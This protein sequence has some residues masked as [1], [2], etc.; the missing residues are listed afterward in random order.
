METLTVVVIC[1]FCLFFVFTPLCST[2]VTRRRHLVNPADLGPKDLNRARRKLSTVTACSTAAASVRPDSMVRT[3]DLE[4]GLFNLEMDECPI[5]IGPLVPEPL[6]RDEQSARVALAEVT[7][8]A[9]SSAE[10]SPAG[11]HEDASGVSSKLLSVL[12]FRKKVSPGS[13]SGDDVLTLTACGHSFHAK[14]LSSWFLIDRYDCP[15]CRI[16]Y[17][18][19]RPPSL[20]PRNLNLTLPS[21]HLAERSRTMGLG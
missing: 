2:I 8:I 19:R 5:C 10:P 4:T 21:A 13:G 6:Q 14:C 16:T 17:Y 1:I 3:P 9:G 20:P 11:A 12:P 18:R 15:I 7:T